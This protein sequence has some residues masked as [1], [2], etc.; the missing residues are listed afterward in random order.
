MAN[1]LIVDDD[2]MLVNALSQVLASMGHSA[3]GATTLVEGLEMARGNGYE[4]V[5]LDVR[6]PDGNGLEALPRFR[7]GP[8][9]PEVIILTGAGDP[10]GAEMAIRSGAWSYITK[11]PTMNNI[12]LPVERAVEYRRNKKESGHKLLAEHGVVG[13]SSA[14]KACLRRA[15]QGAGCDAAV[16][17]TGDTG[18]GKELVARA[19][20][21]NSR[22]KAGPFVVVDCAALPENLVESMLFGHEKGSFTGA[23]RRYGGLVHQADGGT[24]FLDEVGELPLVVQ[25]AFLRVLQDHR[26]R[27]VGGSKELTSDFR[28][29]A[30]TNRDLEDR[31]R[32]GLFREDLLFRIRGFSISLPSLADRDGDVK[33]LAGH[34]L[35]RFCG[36]MGIVPKGMSKDFLDALHRY[37]WPGNVRELMGAM[38]HSLASA[39]GEPN[40]LSRH[41]PTN[42]RVALAR[43]GLGEEMSAQAPVWS[44]EPGEFPSLKDF[45]DSHLADLERFYLEEVMRHA[46]WKV[47]KAIE[48]SGLSRARLYA[49]LKKYGVSR[50]RRSSFVGN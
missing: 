29:L 18:T 25:R 4:L 42:V 32:Q 16:L 26:F 38:E 19:I 15:A 31:V 17:I 33:V 40:L 24:L 1:I 39:E 12:R 23:D 30:A 9:A 28:L 37:S 8:G 41:L 43:A 6:L 44:I 45:R 10:D 22:R 46:G 21:D 50:P 27:P 36:A 7:E 49:L 48:M 35:K 14:I 11:P 34:F 2:T 47:A 3:D 5:I 20:H 13:E